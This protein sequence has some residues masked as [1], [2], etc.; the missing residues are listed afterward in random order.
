VQGRDLLKATGTKIFGMINFF[1][2]E[3]MART[4]S[5]ISASFSLSKE[6]HIGSRRSV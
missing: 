2:E 5:S 1:F 4:S 3:V 6:I